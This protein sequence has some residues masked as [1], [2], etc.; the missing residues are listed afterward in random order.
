[1]PFDP[2]AIDDL[3]ARAIEH[4]RSSRR[5]AES[6]YRLQFHAGFKF[7]DAAA[8]VPYL[9][10]LGISHLYASPYLKAKPGS[11]HGYDVID[12]C[13]LNPELGTMVDYDAL[14]GALSE[15]GMSHIADMVPNHVGVATNEN[16]WWNDVLENGPASVYANYF[17]I[18]WTGSPH[19]DLSG[20]VLIPTLGA[21]YGQELEKGSLQLIFESGGFF[22]AYYDNKFP[23]SPRSYSLILGHE[24]NR[25][26]ADESTRKEIL[27][28]IAECERLP[29]R[30]EGAAVAVKRHRSK[31]QIKQ[32]LGKLAREHEAARN[33]IARTLKVINGIPGQPASFDRLDQLLRHQCFR[34]ASWKT[35][36]DEI[37]YRRFFDVNSLAALAMERL[38]VFNATHGFILGLLAQGKISGLRIDHPDGLYDPQTYF[39]RLQTHYI[40][41]VAREVAK[42]LPGLGDANWDELKPLLLDRLER[43]IPFAGP[44][45]QRWPLYVLG[46]KILALD[47]PLSKAWA[48]NGTS[49]YEFLNMTNGLFVDAS[50]GDAFSALYHEWIKDNTSFDEIVYRKKKLILEIGLASELHMLATELKRI[51]QR[52]RHG[53][54]Y[55]LHGLAMSLK[56]IIACFPV[57]R[58][59]ISSAGPSDLDRKH[60]QQAIDA[61]IRRNPKIEPSVFRYIGESLLIENS[62]IMAFDEVAARRKFAGKFQQLTS[63]V[64]AKGIEDTAFYIYNRLLSLNEVG[65]D[66]SHFGVS[67][68]NLHSFFQKRQQDWPYAMSTLSTHDTKRSEDVRA[69]LNVLS[70]IPRQWRECLERWGKLNAPFRGEI[71][72]QPVPDRNEEYALYQTLVGAWP[73]DRAELESFHAR[74]QATMLKSMREAKV[75]SSWTDPNLKR[76][77]LLH[78]FIDTLLNDRR[79]ETFRADFLAF[80]RQISHWGMLN[81]LSQTLIKLTAPGVPDTYQGNELWDFSLV[82]PDN[83][84]PI[85]FALRLRLME[86]VGKLDRETVCAKFAIRESLDSPDNGRIKLIVMQT[87]LKCRSRFPG[88][89]TAGEYFPLE[90][91]G[92]KADH[93]FAFARSHAGHIA[94][95]AVPRLMAGLGGPNEWPIGPNV[96][97]DTEVIAPEIARGLTFRN[98]FTN[99]E[100]KLTDR[101]AWFAGDLFAD[102]PITLLIS[103]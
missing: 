33:F 19:T 63:P 87:A 27:S 90:T 51:A 31:E 69:R 48:T 7:S 83:R 41:A 72:G 89:F 47:E 65:G 43:E 5:L 57:Y 30:C 22:V 11:T 24:P 6:T 50:S 16:V 53:I 95:A 97:A 88:L 67:P 25:L 9:S 76:E 55:S 37:N 44:C 13:H 100:A 3:L 49:G 61:A 42:T 75:C 54:D 70:E 18:A 62:A 64:T 80:Q 92:M 56:E 52:D 21:M 58:S 77:A 68:Q 79:A 86:E 82:D 60:I 103:E 81:S 23:I 4:I 35:A 98:F 8:L 38:E 12:H 45:A 71:D 1:M 91:R 2:Q 10:D 59:Y 26:N 46:E 93:I 101:H 96:W 36:P 73:L 28:I 99:A 85:D 34:L 32:R 78:G 84:R 39:H 102:C 15:R 17:D 40:V 29:D 74:V 66:P 20:R 14:V 94:I